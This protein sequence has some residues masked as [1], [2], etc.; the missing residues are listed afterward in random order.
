MLAAQRLCSWDGAAHYHCSRNINAPERRKGPSVPPTICAFS[1]T[2][3]AD[4][5]S[6]S[7]TALRPGRC[8][9][10]TLRFSIQILRFHP[11]GT[12]EVLREIKAEA[13]SPKRV[14]TRAE[15]ELASWA[16]RGANGVVIYNH[17]AQKLYEWRLE[18]KPTDED[19]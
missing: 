16:P 14:R 11:N 2:S 13:I 10:A 1:W 7:P 17:A 6:A 5:T 9:G 18:Q 8:P 19:Q 12:S 4:E 15:S 3:G